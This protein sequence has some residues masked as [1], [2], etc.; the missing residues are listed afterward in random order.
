MRKMSEGCAQIVSIYEE[1]FRAD[2]LALSGAPEVT[3]LEIHQLP[4]LRLY[5][6]A[7]CK[8]KRHELKP[9]ILPWI[10]DKWP[11]VLRTAEPFS[12]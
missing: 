10:E 4:H 8:N 1:D 7:R 2:S 11:V 12:Q 5:D 9:A 6:T 3:G